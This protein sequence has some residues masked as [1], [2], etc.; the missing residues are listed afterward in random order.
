VY[1]LCI[2]YQVRNSASI[3]TANIRKGRH[4]AK[5]SHQNQIPYYNN[6]SAA[7]SSSSSCGDDCDNEAPLQHSAENCDASYS[8]S[9]HMSSLMAA[10]QQLTL[11]APS[12]LV[13]NNNNTSSSSEE[14]A[15]LR[16]A[17]ASRKGFRDV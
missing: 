16:E 6:S 13:V 1:I 2:G 11:V 9:K 12:I 5:Y 4:S 17:L 8:A 14:A 15:L 3:G 7:V 10:Q